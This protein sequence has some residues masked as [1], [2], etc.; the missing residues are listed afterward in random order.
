MLHASGFNLP[1]QVHIHGFLTVGGEKMSKSV[2]TYIKAETFLRHL[3]PAYLR[4]YY[5]TKL[6]P[7][8]DDV[9]LNVEE[10]VNKVNADLVNKVVN[11]ASRTAKFVESTGLSQVYPHDGGL[12][13][14]AAAAG[15]SIAEAYECGDYA[16]AMRAII[17]LADQANPF[18]ENAKPWVL[19]KDPAEQSRLQD[20][21]TIALNLFRQLTIY[22]SPVLPKLA[23]QCGELLHDEIRDW[24]Q[25]QKPLVGTPVSKFEHLMQRV[26]KESVNAMMEESKEVSAVSPGSTLS[27]T[28]SSTTPV[29]SDEPLKAEPLAETCS[30]DDF[31]KVDLRVARVL[32][33][34]DVPEAKKLLKLTLSLGGD[35][36]RTVFAGIKAAY[37]PEELVNRLVICVANLAPRQMKFGLSEGMVTAAGP[38]GEEVFL[39]MIDEGA[40]PGMRIH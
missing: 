9:D 1:T 34:E 27:N 37:K 15:E 23:I 5:A 16:K 19:A 36:R 26:K 8:L 2:G 35:H 22:L 6:G 17:E 12:F 24:S 39:L 11:L 3:D 7:R 25:C 4:Y 14:V 18:V 38:G 33:A 21:C 32:S 20:V 30:I 13:Q 10:F 31:T 29:D 40:K 28:A